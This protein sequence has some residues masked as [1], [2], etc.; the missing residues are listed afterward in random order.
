[1]ERAKASRGFFSPFWLERS[2]P[3]SHQ[4]QNQAALSIVSLARRLYLS[5]TSPAPSFRPPPHTPITSLARPALHLPSRNVG[6]PWQDRG[7]MRVSF[8]HCKPAFRCGLAASLA[9]RLRRAGN[10]EVGPAE[11]GQ[12][13]ALLERGRIARAGEPS[14]G[15]SLIQINHSQDVGESSPTTPHRRSR[16]AL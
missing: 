10:M 11:P 7:W 15:H 5:L 6:I 4:P 14:G 16:A 3:V 8:G 1:M 13:G 2:S 12:G 9:T